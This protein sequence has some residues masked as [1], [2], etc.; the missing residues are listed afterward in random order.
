M[1]SGRCRALQLTSNDAERYCCMAEILWYCKVTLGLALSFSLY[2]LKGVDVPVVT[3]APPSVAEHVLSQRN[4]VYGRHNALVGVPP[5]APV[6]GLACPN[7]PPPP[8]A[9][10][11]VDG[12]APKSPVPVPVPAFAVFPNAPVPPPPNADVPVV[13]PNADVPPPP[14]APKPVAGFGAPNAPPPDVVE[15]KAPV[16]IGMSSE[17]V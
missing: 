17:R 16:D 10:V 11:L 9:F 3:G 7:N 4:T 14:N 6:A 8:K 15:P 2:A 5:N 1:D 12:C 13:F